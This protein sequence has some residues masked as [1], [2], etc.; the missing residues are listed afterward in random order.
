M[1]GR[2]IEVSNI[3]FRVFKISCFRDKFFFCSPDKS[4]TV[5]FINRPSFV[6]EAF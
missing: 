3:F 6:P 1:K 4:G 5:T 2:K